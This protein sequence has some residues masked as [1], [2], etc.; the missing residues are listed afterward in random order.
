MEL[1][2][3][4]IQKRQQELLSFTP[5][6]NDDGAV[7]VAEGGSYGTYVDLD[8]SVR[9]E[10]ELITKYRDMAEFPEVDMAIDDIVNELIVQ[11]PE[12][13]VVDLLL[14]DLKVSDQIKKVLSA[15]FEEVLKLL[16]FDQYSYDIGRRW[17][18]DGRLYYHA[19][20]D[21][22]NP[23]LG[24]QEMRYI[25]PRK[26]R[27][28]RELKKK[29]TNSPATV[30]ETGNEYYIYND[31]GFA[32]NS[33]P[34]ATP[35]STVGGIKIAKDSIIQ[36]SS[37]LLS[38][39]GDMILS[40]LQKAIRPLNQLRVMEDALVIYR[41][42]RAPE[43]RLFYIDVGNLPK[44]KAE[45]YVSSLMTK[46]KNK[47][48]YDSNTGE[49]RDDRKYMTMLEDFWLPRR[50]G[51]R[52][53]EISTLPGGQNLDSIADVEYF[54]KRLY[55]SLNV[56][57]SRLDPEA[58]FNFGRATEI[59]R[60]EVKFAKFIGKLRNKFSVLFSKTLGM[61]LVLKGYLTAEEWDAIRDDIKFKFARDNYF[62]ELK[63]SEVLKERLTVLQ[64]ARDYI[65]TAFSWEY[66]RRHILKQ[67]DDDIKEIDEQNVKEK[68]DP[69]LYPPEPEE[70]G[71]PQDN[72]GPEQLDDSINN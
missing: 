62:E 32:K 69:N 25:D 10:A 37:G 46:F 57:V 8:G 3:F 6:Q 53:T 60:D 21:E 56:P 55:K 7:V 47:V 30:T 33:G 72:A 50:E 58:Q 52:G 63:E 49:V 16:E 65:G 19:I 61:N 41:I 44:Q 43:R 68:K 42:S 59:S 40:Y 45:Q 12:E 22:K 36:C 20:T 64:M 24:I 70:G 2:G 51:G 27:K 38:Q 9:T 66:A 31:R 1:F 35:T 28:V 17:Y 71:P 26:I 15:E 48:V 11:E 4:T 29:R 5:K 14:D 13:K 18:V 34:Q 23:G 39:N 67:S 54:Q